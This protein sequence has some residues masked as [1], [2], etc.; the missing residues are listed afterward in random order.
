[1]PKMDGMTF[2]RTLRRQ[3]L[4]LAATPVLVTSTEASARDAA[5]AREAGAN[6]YLVK[7]VAPETLLAHVCAAVRDA[8]MNDLLEQFL[9]ECR[10]LVEAA[11]ADLLALETAPAGH[12]TGSTARSAASTR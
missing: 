9:I 1:M 5:L 2:L 3:A 8:G 11:T 12:R 6:F 4:P 10:E 7:P